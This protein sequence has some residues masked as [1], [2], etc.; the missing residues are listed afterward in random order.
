MD[1]PINEV[2][3]VRSPDKKGRVLVQIYPK[4]K[5]VER[6]EDAIPDIFNVHRREVKLFAS[7]G[8]FTSH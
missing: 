5:K 7:S 6:F 8:Y 1:Y 2:Q 4:F 3:L